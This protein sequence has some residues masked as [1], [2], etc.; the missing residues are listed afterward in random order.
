MGFE[1]YGSTTQHP[2]I[3]VQYSKSDYQLLRPLTE[4]NKLFV[5]LLRI[6]LSSALNYACDLDIQWLQDR[7]VF[8]S[9]TYW[10]LGQL[11][12]SVAP[13]LSCLADHN[14]GVLLQ[15]S[16][17]AVFLYYHKAEISDPSCI[18][19]IPSNAAPPYIQLYGVPLIL[20][21]PSPCFARA[22]Y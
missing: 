4:C 9:T 8:K 18:C 7:S 12:T 10:R 1:H 19:K 2:T 15:A 13:F 22:F 3:S 16:A 5:I 17:S 14:G 21:G 20:P 6:E 11:E